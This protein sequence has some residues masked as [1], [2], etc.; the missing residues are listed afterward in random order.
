[1]LEPKVTVSVQERWENGVAHDERSRELYRFMEAY[2]WKFLGD[3]L[4]LTSG[5]DGDIGE[6][7]MYLMDEYFAA[8]DAL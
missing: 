1:M 6:S 5:G 4:G 8:K 2:D 3:S 7:L